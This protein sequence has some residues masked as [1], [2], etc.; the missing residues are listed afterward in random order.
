[1]VSKRKHKQ[2]FT[3]VG[4]E[5]QVEKDKQLYNLDTR[6]KGNLDIKLIE[7]EYASR[8]INIIRY[9]KQK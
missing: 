8:L 2:K 9:I 7:L 4:K 6:W 1:M 3:T 5:G